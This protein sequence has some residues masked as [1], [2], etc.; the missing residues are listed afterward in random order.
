MTACDKLGWDYMVTDSPPL[1]H[2]SL[3]A[4][5]SFVFHQVFLDCLHDIIRL[6]FNHVT[7]FMLP[8]VVC[9][10]LKINCDV[11]C[12]FWGYYIYFWWLFEP[13]GCFTLTFLRQNYFST[14]NKF[15]SQVFWNMNKG[16][17]NLATKYFHV[18]QQ[19]SALAG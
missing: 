1:L 5:S 9:I 19:V 3:S 10:L 13:D 14:K 15:P 12:A 16:N 17:T 7:Y 4:Q 8:A 18:V 11:F 2:I 6:P